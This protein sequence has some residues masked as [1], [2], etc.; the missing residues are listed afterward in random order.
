VTRLA[1]VYDN[2]GLGNYILS[3]ANMMIVGRKFNKHK[4][5]VIIEK[6][7]K[8]NWNEDNLIT[9]YQVMSDAYNSDLDIMPNISSRF[10]QLTNPTM[11]L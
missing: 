9:L 1:E 11:K 10:L 3:L 6:D 4:D 7:G 5:K 8:L 2:H